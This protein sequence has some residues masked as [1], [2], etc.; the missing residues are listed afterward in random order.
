MRDADTILAIIRDRG[1]RG[2]PLENIYRL[3]YNPALY[4]RA[5]A[6]LYPNKGAMTQGSTEETVDGMS[7]AKINHLIDDLRYE[8]YR[9]T[10]VRR[11][12]I[13]KRSGSL[14]PLGMPTWRDKLLQEVLR[15]ILEAYYEPQFSVR[16]HGFRPHRGCHTA[17][18]DVQTYW[19]GTRWIIE[20]DIKGYFDTID[21]TILL[22]ILGEKLHDQRL[23]RLL[24]HLLEGGYLED[25]RYHKTHSGTPQGGVISPLLANIYLDR[26]DKYI[27]TVLIPA[28]TRGEHRADNLAYL[29]VASA[30]GRAKKRGLKPQAK[31]LRKQMQR[32]PSGDPRDPDYRRLRYVRYADD[33]MLGFIGS[34]HE[35]EAIKQQVATYLQTN[36]H[37]TLAEDKTLLTHIS[38]RAARF[39]GYEIVNQ[40][41]DSKHTGKRRTINGAIGLRVPRDVIMAACARY[42]REGKPKSLPERT[43]DDDYSIVTR[44][45]QEYRGIVQYYALAHNVA[46]LWQLHGVMK[47]SLLKTLAQKH[48]ASVHQMAG[49]YHATTTAPNG[50]ILRC[51][52]VTVERPGKRALTA[53]FGGI[54]LRRETRAILHDDLPTPCGSLRTEILK[55]LVA[56]ECELC[57]AHD[58][59]EVHHIR[60]LADLKRKN[61]KE[62]PRWVIR[63]A[64]RQ[65]K[66]LVV[67][68]ACHQAIQAGQPTRQKGSI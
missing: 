50:T 43:H 55:R 3:L 40:Q 60:K 8:R 49:K 12:Y 30:Y 25:W 57:G 9:W 33:W 11:V 24:R 66:T 47:G 22:E 44:Y 67:C 10:S 56:D 17:L 4:L 54:S 41:D 62:R 52:E 1:R 68:R 15:S 64:A 27:E 34:R 7:V 46:S 20:G 21:H 38:T 14:R 29:R 26:F 45:Q 5:Y 13:P 37:L 31:A 58:N 28:H 19:G 18:R 53:R 51:L 32:L 36:L 48:K 63:M 59:V 6:R 23:L 61:G 35:A 2:L 42:E 65:R 16:S 39:L